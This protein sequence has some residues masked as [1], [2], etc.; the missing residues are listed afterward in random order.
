MIEPPGH[1]HA[2]THGFSGSATTLTGS[3]GVLFLYGIV[4]GAAA[5]LGLGLL[6]A[7]ARRISIN[8]RNAL[9]QRIDPW[10]GRLSWWSRGDSNP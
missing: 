2:L 6:L 1:G 7:A 8:T 5:L 3:T 10:P 9:A 4:I